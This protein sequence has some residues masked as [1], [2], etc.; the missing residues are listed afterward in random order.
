MPLPQTPLE[1]LTA[2]AEDRIGW[3]AQAIIFPVAMLATALT[4]G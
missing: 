3:T 4:F 2:I 1:Q